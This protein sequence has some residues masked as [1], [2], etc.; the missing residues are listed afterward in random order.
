MP[1][2][3]E[4]GIYVLASYMDSDIIEEVLAILEVLS[5]QPNYKS[6]MVSYGVLLA[7]LK[8]L[9]TQNMALHRIALKILYNLSCNGDIGYHFV[10]LNSIT[11]LVPFLC[12]HKLARFCIKIMKNLCAT[13]EVRI[14][15]AETSS[16]ISAIAKLLKT[17]R[18][19][20]QGNVSETLQFLVCYFICL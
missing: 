20:E 11:K 5:Y 7:I 6:M 1:S 9:D 2:F 12:D 17:G 15:V 14:A 4:D 18:E 10:Y 19:E 13:E 16:C 8:A 3:D